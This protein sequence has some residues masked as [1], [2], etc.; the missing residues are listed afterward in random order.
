MSLSLLT[1]MDW[2]A[3]MTYIDT[4]RF[5]PG[6]TRL[7]TLSDGA[8]AV[9]VYLT[10][11]ALLKLFFRN[12]EAWRL[13]AIFIV[14]NL[15]LSLCSLVLLVAMIAELARHWAAGHSLWDQMCDTQQNFVFGRIY[16]YYYC[17]YMFKYWE[18]LDTFMLCVRKKNLQFLH[19]YH[20]PA[21]LVLT[22]V[23][24]HQWMG[25][26]WVVITLNLAV[27]VLMYFYYA[28]SSLGFDLWWKKY[29]TTMQIIQ[30]VIGI[31]I[32]VFGLFRRALHG[33][34]TGSWTGAIFAI[35]ILSSYLF[36]FIRFYL[37][38]YHLVPARNK[39]KTS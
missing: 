27:H 28:W 35:A 39:A 10:I 22:L 38:I 5:V 26:Q 23:M 36:L 1:S 14:H 13:N 25:F 31:S 32:C 29:L 11:I 9:V 6:H 3:W 2:D 16:F 7:A 33:I 34:C 17:N 4:F 30:F 21:T 24:M 15:L 20:H 19:T 12:R 8:I 18:L 37:E